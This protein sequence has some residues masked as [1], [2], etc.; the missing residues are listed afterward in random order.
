M[1]RWTWQI[2]ILLL[3]LA[4]PGVVSAHASLVRANPA[5]NG[6]LAQAPTQI[7]LW[8]DEE[9]EPAFSDIQ[10]LDSTHTRLDTGSVARASGDPKSLVISLKPLPNG[11]FS[12]VWKALSATDGHITR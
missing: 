4:V 8:F 3:F 11:T 5:P 6:V 2:A 10:V 12:V 9:V 1:K 7:Q